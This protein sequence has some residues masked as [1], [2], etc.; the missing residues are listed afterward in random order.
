MNH[1]ATQTATLKELKTAV[2]KLQEQFADFGN[3]LSQIGE[4]FGLVDDDEAG[5][6]PEDDNL[7]NFDDD[8]R[9]DD[10]P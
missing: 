6:T 4:M 2:T 8:E 9:A 10:I 1:M 7:A 5:S 3:R